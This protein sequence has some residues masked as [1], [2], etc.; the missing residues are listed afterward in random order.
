[1]LSIDTTAVAGVQGYVQSGINVFTALFLIVQT[2]ARIWPTP[3]HEQIQSWFGKILNLIFL[4]SKT[5]PE[6]T[7]QQLRA[8]NIDMVPLAQMERN[9][10]DANSALKDSAQA[11]EI[12]ADAVLASA[13]ALRSTRTAKAK[14]EQ[15]K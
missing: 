3:K 8:E 12:A 14:K 7:E 10:V 15:A 6:K 11:V 4:Y 1:M 13:K 9:A 2:V 5:A